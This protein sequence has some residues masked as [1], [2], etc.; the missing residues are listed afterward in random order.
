MEYWIG[1]AASVGLD[2]GRADHLAPFFD[3]FGATE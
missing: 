3:F 1:T 2:I